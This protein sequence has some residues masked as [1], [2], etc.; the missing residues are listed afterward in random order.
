LQILKLYDIITSRKLQADFFLKEVVTIANR[1]KSKKPDNRAQ[2]DE[3]MKYLFSVSK[4]TL[5]NM[6]NSLFNQKF[7][8]DN[9]TI[10][11]TNSEFIDEN[12]DITRGDLFFRVIDE[13]KQYNLHIELQILSKKSDKRCYPGR[14]NI[15]G[16]KYKRHKMAY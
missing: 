15:R 3:I 9:A 4:E 1:K 12:F 2:I 7:S 8:V 10:I 13:S 6:L 11:Q 16:K 14:N 5:I